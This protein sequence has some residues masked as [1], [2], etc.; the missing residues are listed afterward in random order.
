M[1]QEISRISHMIDDM[2]MK[3]NVLRWMV[4][5]RGQQQSA[6]TLSSAD[7]ADLALLSADEEQPGPRPFCQPGQIYV[8]FMLLAVFLV[9]TTLS[10]SVIFFT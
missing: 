4:E 6:E 2:E 9:A 10:V 1:E 3:V 8:F 7:S 5:P